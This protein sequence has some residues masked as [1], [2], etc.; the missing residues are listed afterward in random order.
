MPHKCGFLEVL[1]FVHCKNTE[2]Y[3]S[4]CEDYREQGLTYRSWM[5]LH[6]KKSKQMQHDSSYINKNTDG[7]KELFLFTFSPEVFFRLPTKDRKK[8]HYSNCAECHRDEGLRRILKLKHSNKVSDILTPAVKTPAPKRKIGEENNTPAAKV[9]SKGFK[10]LIQTTPKNFQ[11]AQKFSRKLIYEGNKT[12]KESGFA[13]HTIWDLVETPKPIQTQ[14]ISN[15]QSALRPVLSEQGFNALFGTSQSGRE[16]ERQRRIQYRDKNATPRLRA[17]TSPLDTYKYDRADLIIKITE[18]EDP[19]KLNYT[20]LAKE[21]NLTNKRD[22]LP[23][24]CGQVRIDMFL[25][26][27]QLHHNTC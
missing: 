23:G 7:E 3:N 1:M 20:K 4:F 16:Y 9:V 14:I 15:S 18:A 11:E 10:T 25:Y 24:N 8:H 13:S 2:D 27:P 5:T 12:L 21:V 22:E 26:L 19:N 17:H 6:K